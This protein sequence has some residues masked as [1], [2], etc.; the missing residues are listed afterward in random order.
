M[1][2][3]GGEFKGRRKK[4]M[5]G[6]VVSKYT[7][8]EKLGEGGMGEVY[9]AEDTDL[10]RKVALKFLPK[11]FA[12]DA[13]TLARF[14]RE[15]QTAA[16]LNHP[17]IITVYEVGDH[18]GRPFIA[19]AYV[20]GESLAEVIARNDMTVERALDIA[21]QILAGLDNAH[22][23][24][25]VH[26]DIKPGNI[27]VDREGH[28][29]ILDFGLAKLAG[30]S[31]LT[32]DLSTMGTIFYM[33]PEQTRGEDIDGRSD[34]FSL[35]AVLYE[36]LAGRPAFPGEHTAAV[37]YSI[38][39]EE[40]KPLSRFYQRIPQAIEQV[41]SKALE[42]KR[43][44]RYDS[45]GRMAEDL[46]RLQAGMRPLASRPNRGVL[47]Y[48]LPTSVVFL[49]VALFFVF[50]P[51]EFQI[52][53]EQ[54]AVAAGNSLAI[55]YFEN[56]V[57]RED[58]RRLGEI[59]TNL[60]ITD[61]S[62]SDYIQVVSSQRL[63]DILKLQGKEGVKVIDR[64]TATQVAHHAGAK[65]MLLGSILQEEPTLIMTSQLVDVESGRI[66]ASQR[67]T[68][69]ADD[70]VFA[71][72]DQLTD[73]VQEDLALPAAARGELDSPVASVT[74]NSA[75]AYR[76]YLEGVEYV[77]KYYGPE[78]K[79]CFEK[80]LEYDST[81]AMV[82]L[83]MASGLFTNRAE[84]R[85][86]IGKA[87]RY[88]EKASKTEKHYIQSTAALVEGDI[89]TAIAELEAIIEEN[90]NEKDAYKA[91]GDIYRT[92][93]IDSEKAIE[94]YRQV[95]EFDP[96]D[97]FTYNVLA[98]AYQAAGDIDNYIWAIYQYM[99]LAPDEANPYDS[100]G[101]LYAFS[102]KLD[103]AIGSYGEA[104]ER[105]PDFGPSLIKMGHMHLF[106][107]DYETAKTYYDRVAA[108]GT[109][110]YRSWGR[111][112]LALIPLH[113][114]KINEG[115]R[116]LR[117]GMAADEAEGFF[118]DGYY[119]KGNAI[120]SL[121]SFQ[122]D[123]D[124]GL[125]EGEKW[126]RAF[127][128]RYPEDPTF[129]TGS[130]VRMLARSGDYEGAKK[131]L[132]IY[133]ESIEAYD[134]SRKNFYTFSKG[135]I[136]FAEGVVDSAIVNFERVLKNNEGF[137]ARYYL[138]RSYLKAGRVI[139][140]VNEFDRLLRR[141]SEDRATSPIEGSLAYYY[142][143]MAYEE[144]GKSEKAAEQYEK[145]LSKWGD[146]DAGIDEVADAR[147]RLSKLRQTG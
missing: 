140:A 130:H 90:P 36:M 84:R 146:A 22:Q 40:P 45:A 134:R 31:K 79:V 103:K 77:N 127:S 57:D 78:A 111:L 121:Y 16:G 120:A 75:E 53:A 52:S 110:D 133:R 2:N 80:A 30:A 63:Y 88:S 56:V 9:L 39:N 107:N 10:N 54:T 81:F 7:I 139:E 125:A 97:K 137:Y 15:A 46:K 122:G 89:D 27:F 43:D 96:M 114:G 138:A 42:K 58:P 147:S 135:D 32:S 48:V 28:V 102:G 38:T 11:Q 85:E 100:R 129:G 119:E 47:K 8:L 66:V 113:Q 116:M 24:G 98:Y 87:I 86:A 117:E 12:S 112:L 74:T 14:K 20:D 70:E 13:D 82:Y 18:K 94:Y 99:A 64:D 126:R 131:Q 5:I 3:Y 124:K 6:S 105:K 118:G 67:V 41:V 69:D 92:R 144:A 4:I 44:D 91:L 143:G 76:H 109:P 141:F 26:R 55:M 35:G 62:E 21:L 25:I 60:L 142:F 95:I 37:V 145:F 83:R 68:G 29:K 17:N 106:K 104:L 23:A 50:K 93:R 34:L 33:S 123:F 61:L 49:A 128:A 101:D 136:A 71:L 65:W 73:E 1:V 51:F 59:V 132:E 115:I 108:G 72:V 19:M